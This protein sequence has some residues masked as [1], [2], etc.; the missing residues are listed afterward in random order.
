MDYPYCGRDL[1]SEPET[2]FYASCADAA[3]IDAWRKNRWLFRQSLAG[4]A[5]PPSAAVTCPPDGVLLID[6]LNKVKSQDQKTAA[7]MIR[8]F[9]TKYE[10]HK[11]LF[12]SYLP[13]GKRH[14][15]SRLAS[16]GTYIAFADALLRQ[17][18]AGHLKYLSTL[19]KLCD[20]LASQS[21]A[22][23]TIEEAG[24]LEMVLGAEDR[25]VELLEAPL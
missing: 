5:E 7:L 19:L 9:V 15:D 24:H 18:E 2:Y 6:I 3:Y 25:L 13:S 10:V 17:A 8:P 16:L 11:R 14:A 12:D 4:P 22:Q 1:F 23:Y 21:A 20:A